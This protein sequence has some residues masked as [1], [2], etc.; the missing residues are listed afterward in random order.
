L[1]SNTPVV[2]VAPTPLD[3][4]SSRNPGLLLTGNWVPPRTAIMKMLI[5]VFAWML[6]GTFT[7]HALSE[8]E[9]RARDKGSASRGPVSTVSPSVAKSSTLSSAKP[10]APSM[11]PRCAEFTCF[12]AY[13][14]RNQKCQNACSGPFRRTGQC[15]TLD[16]C[17]AASMRTVIACYRHAA[18]ELPPECPR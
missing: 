15:A 17:L 7:A 1:L 9:T 12:P 16:A 11:R 6:F 8:A 18:A 4:S 2:L 5:C 14:A 10:S 3:Q 13:L